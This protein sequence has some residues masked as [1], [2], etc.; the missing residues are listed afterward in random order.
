M[1]RLHL[2]LYMFDYIEINL[3]IHHLPAG[4]KA[5]LLTV[6]EQRKKWQFGIHYWMVRTLTHT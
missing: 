2:K 5:S 3:I 6:Y 1:Y 4:I